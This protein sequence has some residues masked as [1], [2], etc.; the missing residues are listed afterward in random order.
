MINNK[1]KEILRIYTISATNLLA[2]ACFTIISSFYSS[3]ALKSGVPEALIGVIFSTFPLFSIM[4]SFFVPFLMEKFSRSAILITGL[5]LISFSSML[6]SALESF[7]APLSIVVSFASRA[8]SGTGAAFEVIAANSI[9]T[10]DYPENVQKI[11]ALNEIFSCLGLILGP[12]VGSFIFV[13]GGF[14]V[15][16]FSVGVVVLAYVPVLVLAVG[17]GNKYK[18]ESRE[19]ISVGRLVIRP[20]IEI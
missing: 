13:Y 9:L 1:M 11:M 8:I 6:I 16:C 12:V 4:T 19:S 15:S 18:I 10:S 3:T 5:V 7:E 14:F 20:V 17:R 2:S